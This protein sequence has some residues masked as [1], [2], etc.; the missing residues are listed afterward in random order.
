MMTPDQARAAML[1]AFEAKAE[2][3]MV[4]LDAALG[5]VLARDVIAARDQPPFANSAMDGY[6]LRASDTPGRLRV[7]GESA[8][9]R[10]YQQKL[11]AGEAVRI[12]TGAPM[13]EGA[14]SVLIQEEAKRDGATLAAPKVEAGAH[15]RVRGLDFRAGATLLK[16]GE[17]LDGIGLALA[18]AS[19]AS[20]LAVAKPL[21]VAILATGDEIVAPGA[22]PAWDQI[23]ESCSF[24]VAGLTREWGAE[25]ERLEAQGDDV[26]ALAR[27]VEAG[28]RRADLVVTIGGASVGDHDLVR[29]AIAR[30]SARFVVEKIGVRPGKPTFFARTDLG[31][32]LGLP[33]N[34]ASGLVCSWLFLRP[35]IEHWHGRD[36][37][38]AFRQA[39]LAADMPAN[40]P[41]EHYLRA[42]LAFEGAQLLVRAAEDQDSS[43]LSIFQRANALIRRTP[44]APPAAR[45]ES[46]EVLPLGRG[47]SVA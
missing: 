35:L 9:G 8:A 45:G 7:A 25:V 38:P 14:D 43:R 12:F 27:A 19:G 11:Q 29:T 26:D 6:A 5:R 1:A 20:A 31:P 41:R 16:R 47:Q 44:N 46:T 2:T 13:P 18:A 21:R 33:G 34:P 3:E 32:V 36:P 39:R 24:G 22:A 28:W 17:R 37:T 15:V 30:F 42:Q 40:G 10:G 23:Y 4:A